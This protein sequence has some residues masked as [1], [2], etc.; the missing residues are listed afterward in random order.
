M[1]DLV[2]LATA[3]NIDRLQFC[4]GGNGHSG[5]ELDT[6]KKVSIKSNDIRMSE[7]F[8]EILIKTQSPS[9]F[10]KNDQISIENFCW[11]PVHL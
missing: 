9:Y 11:T 8:V 6:E 4:L 1:I 3:I 5:L 10:G 2:A 7:K